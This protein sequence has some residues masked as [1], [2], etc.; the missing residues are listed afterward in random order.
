MN[1]GRLTFVCTI[2]FAVLFGVDHIKEGENRMIVEK[3]WNDIEQYWKQ[4][5]NKV[6]LGQGDSRKDILIF[7]NKYDIDLPKD[8]IKSLER[9]YQNSRQGRKALT[10]PWFGNNVGID[11]LSLKEINEIYEEYQE[12]SGLEDAELPNISVLYIGGVDKYINI[13]IWHKSWIPIVCNDDLPIVLFID[14]DKNSKNY[15]KVIGFYNTYLE[16][17]GDHFRFTYIANNYIEFLTDLRDE[18]LKYQSKHNH[19]MIEEG[20]GVGFEFKYYEKKF[21][22]PKGFWTDEYR[23]RMIKK[24]KL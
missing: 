6:S 1:I 15:Q 17:V 5:D 16:G 7:E 4:Y 19:K 2:M 13:T 10:Y 14:L 22:L 12:Y 8:L 20:A 9:N 21:E 3:V 24:L 23:E 18:F 11:L